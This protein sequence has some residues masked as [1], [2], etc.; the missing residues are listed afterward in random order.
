MEPRRGYCQ[1]GTDINDLFFIIVDVSLAL[2]SHVL[3][4]NP[5]NPFSRCGDV[6][7]LNLLDRGGPGGS[8]ALCHGHGGGR[9]VDR[10]ALVGAEVPGAATG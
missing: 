1:V 4:I 3:E 2:A 6:V 10:A 5:P 8:P 9:L 7:E